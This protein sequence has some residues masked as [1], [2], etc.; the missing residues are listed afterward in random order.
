MEAETR[1]GAISKLALVLRGLDKVHEYTAQVISWLNLV[2]AGL[3]IY[4]VAMRYFFGAPSPWAMPLTGKLFVFYWMLVG[5]YVLL[6][7]EHVRLDILY[8]RLA[9]RKQAILN[10]ITYLLFFFY[11]GLILVYGWDWFLLSYV[12]E[13]RYSGLWRPL[14]WPFRLVVPLSFSLIMLAGFSDLMRNLHLAITG[15]ELK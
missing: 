13:A 7:D 10:S 14:V 9:P 12:R 1:A 2:M 4:H 3:L 8:Q 15:R 11:C 6:Q 5:G